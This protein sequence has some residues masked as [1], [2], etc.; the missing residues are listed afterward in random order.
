MIELKDMLML[1]HFIEQL[2]F[3]D[4][5]ILI[6][7]DRSSI[8]NYALNSKVKMIIVV[9]DKKLTKEQ[10]QQAKE[11]K[12]NI[13]CTPKSSFKIARVLC[14]ANPIKSIKR[15]GSVITFNKDDY[16][17]DF[18]EATAKLKHTNYP[19]VDNNNRCS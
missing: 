4:D 14:L 11:N 17:T 7:G 18:V 6:V 9:K 5:D 13:I 8:I 10:K 15:G 12:I 3:K 2:E 1:Q 19:I 16:L